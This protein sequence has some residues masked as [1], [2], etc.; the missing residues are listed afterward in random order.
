MRRKGI[1]FSMDAIFAASL[2]IIALVL[3]IDTSYM[4][5]GSNFD[6]SYASNDIV[7]AFSN[8]KISEVN[9]SYIKQLIIDGEINNTENSLIE[10]IGE[11]YVLNMSDYALNISKELV[12]ILIPDKHG[13]AIIINDETVYNNN[14]SLTSEL[15]TSRRLISGIEKFKPVRGATSK[16]YLEGITEKDDSTYLYFGGFV[17]QGNI[18]VFTDDVPS[19]IIIQSAHFEYASAGN[20]SFYVN[21]V[22]CDYFTKND[23]LLLPLEYTFSESC[24]NELV[25]GSRNSFEISFNDSINNSY[26]AGGF[27]RIDYT[28]DKMNYYSDNNI[29]RYNLPNIE[30]IINIYDSV[31]S[32]GTINS[33]KVFLHYNSTQYTYLNIGGAT[34]YSNNANGTEVSVTLNNATL[35]NLLSY[36]FLS[37]KTIPIRMASYNL[38]PTLSEISNADVVLITDFSGSMKKNFDTS[39]PGSNNYNCPEILSDYD[40]RRYQHAKCLDSQFLDIIFNETLNITGGRVWPISLYD[41]N[42]DSYSNNPTDPGLINNFIMSTNTGKG[43]TCLSCVM[44]AA[45]DIFAANNEP[46]R[47]RFIVFMTD[48][49]P[50]HI[51][52][53]GAFGTSDVFGSKVCEGYCDISGSCNSGPYEGCS[54]GDTSCDS[55]IESTKY[56]LN[57]SVNDFNV[58][59]Y[60]VGFGDME[61]QCPNAVNFL[62]ELANMT[63]NGTFNVSNNLDGLLDIYKDIAFDILMKTNQEAQLVNMTGNMTKG[64]LY[65]DS[66]IEFNVTPSFNPPGFG[67]IEIVME[68]PLNSCNSTVNVPSQIRPIEGAITSYSSIHWT[69]NISVNNFNTFSL[70]DYSVYYTRLGDPF[71]I[72]VPQSQILGLSNEIKVRLADSPTNITPDCPTNN[73]FIYKGAIRSE[74]SYSDVLEKVV[75]CNWTVESDDFNLNNFLVPPDYSGSKKCNYT[76]SGVFGIGYDHEDT[77]DD[78]MFKLMSQL[79]FNSDG[80]IF[81]N[82]DENNLIINSIS[83]MKIPYPWGPTIAEVRIWK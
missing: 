43:M 76:S 19:G 62:K 2:L 67:E 60:A 22:F 59:M 4:N 61:N 11:F 57:R 63:E 28:T 45:Y 75:G 10:Q 15:V 47:E 55:A 5:T 25:V 74:V 50:T 23:N 13:F 31:Y 72:Y 40:I 36:S 12:D 42:V 18:S 46:G 54:L 32:S 8:I 64:V 70:K 49:I 44:N 41:D 20:F 78:A 33:M 17:G 83:I 7:N 79:D 21:D 37:N 82:L 53:D 35:G 81:V 1:I 29:L 3:L 30:G 48:G 16:V 56:A 6:I 27:I 80:R 9:N 73:S 68:E 77:Y 39:G 51:P 26:I 65:G 69:H 66:Y 52:F 14:I 24:K 38:T 58:S 71:S 34:V